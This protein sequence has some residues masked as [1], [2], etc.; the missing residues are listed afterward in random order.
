VVADVG[1]LVKAGGP[2]LNRGRASDPIR[3]VRGAGYS[4]DDRFGRTA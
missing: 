4:F 3:T 2:A 1:F